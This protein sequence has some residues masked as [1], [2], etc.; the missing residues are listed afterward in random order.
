MVRA[1][2]AIQPYRETTPTSPLPL[3]QNWKRLDYSVAQRFEEFR[4]RV[5]HKFE[6]I[7]RKLPVVRPLFDNGEIIHASRAGP[8]FR[9]TAMPTTAQTA[10]QR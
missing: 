2:H 9:R 3:L 7:A 5:L 1:T 6:N 4:R 10:A 8:K